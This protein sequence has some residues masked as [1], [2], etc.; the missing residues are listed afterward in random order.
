MDVVV[1]KE[2]EVS[3]ILDEVHHPLFTSQAV[4]VLGARH[5][6]ADRERL[7]IQELKDQE[8]II[9]SPA[10]SLGAYISWPAS[11]QRNSGPLK[12]DKL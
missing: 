1:T 4:A 7:T 9:I 10:E 6:L 5:P 12:M 8:F 11:L 3:V 2:F